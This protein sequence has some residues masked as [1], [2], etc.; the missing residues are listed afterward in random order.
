MTP[1]LLEFGLFLLLL[2]LYLGIDGLDL[3]IDGLAISPFAG[4]AGLPVRE[5]I[6]PLARSHPLA[7]KLHEA[8]GSIALLLCDPFP[9][10]LDPT[11]GA[12]RLLVV[13][14]YRDNLRVGLGSLARECLVRCPICQL[15]PGL[16]IAR[17][18]ALGSRSVLLKWRNTFFDADYTRH[19]RRD[20]SAADIDRYGVF[21]PLDDLARNLAAPS[22]EDVICEDRNGRQRDDHDPSLQS[23]SLFP[24]VMVGV[25]HR[26]G[27]R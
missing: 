2:R 9:P 6:L 26:N 8:T 5:D 19:T 15:S 11:E 23:A 3:G 10:E 13:R 4:V 18:D 22:Q 20:G 16:G 21:R 7:L 12:V 24:V 25:Y 17:G 1:G 14:Q 27:A